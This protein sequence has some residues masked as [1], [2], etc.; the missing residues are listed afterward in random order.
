MTPEAGPLRILSGKSVGVIRVKARALFRSLVD[1]CAPPPS[2]PPRDEAAE[3]MSK[4]S[5][6]SLCAKCG[7]TTSC[8]W[9]VWHGSPSGSPESAPYWS[10]G[11]GF[12]SLESAMAA[13][14]ADV[15][16]QLQDSNGQGHPR[17]RRGTETIPSG[18]GHRVFVEIW[19]PN[20]APRYMDP[21]PP[22]PPPSVSRT[23]VPHE[24]GWRFW[25]QMEAFPVGHDPNFKPSRPRA[26][27]RS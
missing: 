8:G 11:H 27:R 1:S 17:A 21:P 24:N 25:Y 23:G 26:D 9:V 20:A 6:G 15:D 7:G 10:S 4:A 12:D 18:V 14:N 16:S 3:G 22:P 13:I 2:P 19:S 5:E